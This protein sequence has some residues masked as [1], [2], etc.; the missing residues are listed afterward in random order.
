M[1]VYYILIFIPYSSDI[2]YKDMLLKEPE[3]KDVLDMLRQKSA[4]WKEF[5][6]ALDVDDNLCDELTKAG[7]MASSYEKLDAVLEEWIESQCSDVTWQKVI[8][9][10]KKLNLNRTASEVRKFLEQDKI[11]LKYYNCEDFCSLCDC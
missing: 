8:D 9:V 10:L 3:K 7:S 4:R 11:K 6:I 1:Y 2:T 5:A